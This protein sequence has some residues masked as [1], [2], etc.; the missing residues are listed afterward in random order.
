MIGMKATEVD[1]PLDAGRSSPTGETIRR[2]TVG[3]FEA[4]PTSNAVHQVVRQLYTLC[5]PLDII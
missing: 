5:S 4:T 1:D 3:V 2:Y